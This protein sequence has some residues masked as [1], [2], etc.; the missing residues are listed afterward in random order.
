MC[1]KKGET[2]KGSLF[3]KGSAPDGA[4][5]RMKNGATIIAEVSIPAPTN[6]WKEYPIQFTADQDA[7]DASMQIAFSGKVD[8]MLDQVSLMS[9]SSISNDGFR[10]DIY[11]AFAALK[12]TIIRWP[13]GVYAEQY[14]WKNGIGPQSQRKKS[15]TPLW[16]DY[17]P[18]SLGTDEYITLCRKLGAEPLLV[19]NTGLH[20]DGGRTE[21]QWKPWIEEACDWVQY[22]NGPVDSA[23]G[24][25]RAANG[26][27]EPYHVKYWEIDNELWRS[28]QPNPAVY[29]RALPLFADAMKKIDPSI[30]I[31]AHG[32]NDADRNYDRRLLSSIA[33][34]FNI[35]SIH[36]Y[37]QPERFVTNIA[38]QDSLYHDLIE[39]IK[40]SKNPDIKLDV[41]EWN[42][43]SIDWRTGL[44]AGAL[45]NTFEKYGANLTIAGPALLFRHTSAPAWDNAFINFNH[46]GY[47]TAP[48]YVV[49][50]LWREHFAPER[51]SVDGDAGQ[52]NLIATRDQNAGKV[53]LKAVNESSADISITATLDGSGFT[54][55]SADFALVAPG[56]LDARNSMSQP[57]VVKP[58]AANATLDKQ[59]IHFTM[60][61]YSAGAITIS[62]SKV[63]RF[64][65]DS[66]A[67]FGPCSVARSSIA[68]CWTLQQKNCADASEADFG[69]VEELHNPSRCRTRCTATRSLYHGVDGGWMAS[70]RYCRSLWA[71]PDA[72]CRTG[73]I[74]I[75]TAG[76]MRFNPGRVRAA[77]SQATA[78]AKPS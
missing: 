76:S 11:G 38:A 68:R 13:G 22:C 9:Q 24:K 12:P 5:V 49:M 32:G 40:S 10:P 23:W 17:D 75:A 53:I 14:H 59:T 47:F 43:Q 31:I 34:S 8:A 36:H 72:A 33:S 16:N 46:K 30:T 51:L 45:L 64:R 28:L 6:E 1:L 62:K 77:P 66:R 71:G 26:H 70:C 25:V 2:Y 55:G 29:A 54:P 65:I 15:I 18:N 35:L 50:K 78:V 69:D 67:Q 20:V 37:A 44:Y 60:P 73:R 57:N 41:S 4:K 3:L 52:L 21:E 7:P 63:I 39:T 42:A 58:I 61:A 27:P 74:P 48:N 19:I 56:N